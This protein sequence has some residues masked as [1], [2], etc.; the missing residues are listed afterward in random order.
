MCYA[1]NDKGVKIPVSVVEYIYN[2]LREDNLSFHHTLYHQIFQESL[3]HIHDE[4]FSTPRYFIAH[5]N[6]QISQLSVDL[7]SA[8]YQLS[9]IYQNVQT[10]DEDR[11]LEIVPMMTT[12][13]KY[14][15]VCEELKELTKQ[16]KDPSVT[17]DKEQ[18]NSI[19][20]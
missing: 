9:K 18:C 1:Q 15:I 7:I 12:T 4:R 19:M 17:S 6:P 14:A 20:K 3:A 5:P 13:F 16:L 8:P 11:L 2:D 10:P